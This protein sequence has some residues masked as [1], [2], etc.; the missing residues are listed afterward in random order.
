VLYLL[1]NVPFFPT[2]QWKYD[3]LFHL[4][5]SSHL[6]YTSWTLKLKLDLVPL[7]FSKYYTFIPSL[8]I[9][10]MAGLLFVLFWIAF[11]FLYILLC[12][13]II[14]CVSVSLVA[15]QVILEVESH[16]LNFSLEDLVINKLLATLYWN[17]IV[18]HYHIDVCVTFVL[19]NKVLS[20]GQSVRRKW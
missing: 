14:I 18:R 3:W 5:K 2:T 20:F 6:N 15:F 8:I 7:F 17:V 9:D 4:K 10:L 12:Y 13:K 11:C 1:Y 19:E 16:Y